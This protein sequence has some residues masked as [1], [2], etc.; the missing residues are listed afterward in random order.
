M[1]Q[2]TCLCNVVR[3]LVRAEQSDCALAH[4]RHPRMA[5]THPH[6]HT[7]TRIHSALQPHAL[8]I[9]AHAQLRHTYAHT[10]HTCTHA[11]TTAP[12][13]RVVHTDRVQPRQQATRSH[14]PPQSPAGAREKHKGKKQIHDTFS[15]PLWMHGHI[16]KG[17][18]FSCPI[19]YL[20]VSD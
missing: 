7:H 14:C 6:P 10:Q 2:R 8:Q 5:H 19:T 13:T 17:S 18:I 20:H 4:M 3:A 1:L 9:R 16:D 11:R 12:H 15:I